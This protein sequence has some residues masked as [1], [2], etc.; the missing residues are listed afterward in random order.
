[1][2]D[3]DAVRAKYFE[4]YGTQRPTTGLWT[5]DANTIALT[6][7]G[8]DVFRATKGA[9]GNSSR[10][11]AT[12]AS[13]ARVSTDGNDTTPAVTEEFVSELFVNGPMYI[14]GFAN[15]NGS[16]VAGNLNVILYD[17][18][19]AIVANTS[20]VGVAQSGTDA[21]QRIPFSAP[22]QL[23][24]GTYYVGVQCNNIAARLN[25]HAGIGNWGTVKRTGMVFGTFS[26]LTPPTTFTANVGPM[27]SLY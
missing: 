15:F 17:R 24:G 6:I 10:L 27:G 9:T 5:P 11:V 20:A 1:M 2:N 3:F 25:T 23:G 18:A 4:P 14:T 21:Y 22:V 16:A 12:G 8:V 26:A 19:G 13:P 7:G